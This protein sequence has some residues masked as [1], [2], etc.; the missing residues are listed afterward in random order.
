MLEVFSPSDPVARTTALVEEGL[1]GV[2]PLEVWVRA[3]G[4]G[5]VDTAEVM[6]ALEEVRRRAESESIVTSSSSPSKLLHDVWAIWSGD[7]ERRE[8][9]FASS[10]QVHQLASL[11]QSG[12]DDPLTPWW[13]FDGREAR[14]QFRLSDDGGRE[15]LAFGARVQG[16]MGEA[17]SGVP[18]VEWSMTGDA[19]VAALGLRAFIRDLL[20]SLGAAVVIIFG[21]MMLTF[22]SVR[23]GVLSVPANLLPLLV[24]LGFMGWAGIE[25]N[26]T[27]VILF[28]VSLGLAVDDTIHV[29]ARYAEALRL[30]LRG[31]EAV[32]VACRGAGRAI[33]LTSLLLGVGLLVLTASTFVPT[34]RFATLTAM[35]IAGCLVADLVLLPALLRLWPE[36]EG[37]VERDACPEG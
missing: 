6:N 14:L 16:W 34:V 4:G 37:A 17:F 12:T 11:L 22:R 36:G 25:L 19:W 28:S 1:E 31:E 18:D 8:G 7:P 26:T 9:A 5:R 23:L 20:S 29:L 24:T 3:T 35:T 13:T 32:A 30:G 2:L 15:T 27:T 33:V 21:F 10:A